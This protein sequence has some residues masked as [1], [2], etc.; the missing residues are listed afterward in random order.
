MK[1]SQKK[2]LLRKELIKRKLPTNISSQEKKLFKNDELNHAPDF[3]VIKKKNIIITNNGLPILNDI[4]LLF[5]YLD[6][7]SVTNFKYIKIILLL[8]KYYVNVI[9]YYLNIRKKEK[10]IEE[11]VFVNNRHSYGYF[12]WVCDTLPKLIFMKKNN[13][14]N[15]KKIVINSNFQKFHQE[16]CKFINP[17]SFIFQQK[18]SSLIIKNFYYLSKIH[19]SGN[20][21]KISLSLLRNFF[22]KKKNKLY[23]KIYISRKFQNKRAFINEHEF[24]KYLRKKKFEIHYF[25]NYSIK[26][27]IDLIS[28]TKLL[29]GFSGAGLVNC[30]WLPKN[31]SIIDLRPK[32]D[33]YVNPFFSISN[34]IKF[35]YNF[36]LCNKT[37][38]LESNHYANFMIDIDKFDKKFNKIL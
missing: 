16:Y 30:I 27:Q 14:F 10:T 32:T 11:A 26:K 7:N 1:N 3:Y 20:P 22:I 31:S 4:K 17:R 9:Y 2:I 18:N 28:K 19:N 34:I 5:D 13:T 25:E 35:K 24:C 38:Y 29:I 6:L 23:K 37:N 21:R 36:F 8:L 33:K 15:K 12:H